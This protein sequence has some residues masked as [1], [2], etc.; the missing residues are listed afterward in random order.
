MSDS[1]SQ[2]FLAITRNTT[3]LEWLQGARRFHLGLLGQLVIGDVLVQNARHGRA[4]A[5]HGN[6]GWG[7]HGL[8]G[9]C[10]TLDRNRKGL[11]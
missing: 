3:D 1:L 6:F 8:G 5:A 11:Q 10:E 7:G 9:T 2:T 4:Q